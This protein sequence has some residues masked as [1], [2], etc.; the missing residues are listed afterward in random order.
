MK[1]LN[2]AKDNEKKIEIISNYPI[3]N[4]RENLA[5]FVALC[6][7]N[8]QISFTDLFGEFLGVDKADICIAWRKLS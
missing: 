7:G 1:L 6:I 5:E 4:T 2:S 3:P 8:C